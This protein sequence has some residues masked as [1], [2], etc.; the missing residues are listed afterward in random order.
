VNVTRFSPRP[1][2]PAARLAPLGPRLARQRSRALATLRRRIA[3]ERM[4]RWIGERRPARVM[5]YGPGGSSVA[6]LENYLPVVLA[7]RP[8][9]GAMVEVRI[10]GARSTYL[11]G[12]TGEL[13]PRAGL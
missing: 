5:E 3:R 11:L 1:G 12:A 6:R 2:T 4:E 8:P 10:D 7:S 9:L 13:P